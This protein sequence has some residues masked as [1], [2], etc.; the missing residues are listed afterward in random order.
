MSK[1]SIVTGAD[2][3]LGRAVA[4]ALLTRGDRLVL[5]GRHEEALEQAFSGMS[6]AGAAIELVAADLTT[7]EGA[8]AVAAA[9]EKRFGCIDVLCHLAG[10]FRM[11]S[12]VDATSE[13][14]WA[15]LQRLNV[16]SLRHVAAAVVPAMLR[17]P[18]RA[19]GRAAGAIVTVGAF[20]ALRGMAG[21]GAY[22]AAKAAVQRLSEAMAAELRQSI[23]VNCVLPSILD[24]PEN[25]AAMPDADHSE[26]IALDALADVLAFLT[27]DAARA[28]RGVA[29]PVT[30]RSG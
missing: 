4:D 25:R 16:D 29:L 24:T 1:V 12:R 18:G 8:R 23:N 26:W 10:G 27:S 9:A 5:S 2:G 30:G 3:N 14:D 6:K 13:D 11:G 20:G 17:V 19:E 21:M 22:C 28:V 15:F 7:A